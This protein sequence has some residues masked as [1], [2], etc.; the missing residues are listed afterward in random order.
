MAKTRKPYLIK[1][2]NILDRTTKEAVV[3]FTFRTIGG[4]RGRTLLKPSE[5]IDK[6]RLLKHLLD[7]N[8]VLPADAER[9]A[10]LIERAAAMEPS[11]L[12]VQPENMGWQ[13]KGRGFLAATG[14]I[15]YCSTKEVALPAWVTA[16]Q[17]IV[18][19]KRGTLDAWVQE[20]GRRSCRSS[21]ALTAMCAAFAAPL[22]RVAKMPSFGINIYGVSKVGKTSALLAASSVGGIGLENRMP[23]FRSTAAARG[24]LS[25]AFN[26]QLLALNEVGLLAGKRMA[27]GPIRDLIY[28]VS[29]GRD[30]L[31]HSQSTYARAAKASE[32]RTIFV[33]TSEHSFDQYAKFAQERRDEGEYARCLDIAACA[34][35]GHTIMDRVPKSVSTSK[36]RAWRRDEVIKLR[37]ACATHHGHTLPAY[38]DHLLGQGKRL[39]EEVR[40]GQKAF[41]KAI[42]MKSLEGALQ[43]A[44]RNFSLL[45]AGGRLAIQA[46]LLPISE[47]K[48]MR[49]L[50]AVFHRAVAEIAIFQTPDRTIR[51]ILGKEVER[52]QVVSANGVRLGKPPK[53]GFAK[54]EAGELVYTIKSTAFRRWFSY[55]NDQIAAALDFLTRKGFLVLPQR[56]SEMKGRHRTA[57]DAAV[58]FVSWPDGASRR[59]LVFRDPARAKLIA[60]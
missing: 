49:I 60:A 24:E 57:L 53:H 54:E 26:D 44:A 40:I 39:K 48:L 47:K 59:S 30:T 55:N 5:L 38:I 4:G 2:A 23:N 9:R 31:R 58:R 3:E 42:D 18:Q 45:A 21:A 35:G 17:V 6:D 32:F 12:V 29:E 7:R 28:Q 51:A 25:C 11:V 14:A 50:I 16:K 13:N 8:A 43:H 1:T 46:G 22:L 19:R 52:V 56:R 36:R 27:Y 15:G 41:L 34:E 37:L 10:R 33:S 20:V